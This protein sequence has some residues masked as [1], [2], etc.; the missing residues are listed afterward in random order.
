MDDSKKNILHVYDKTGKF[1][2]EIILE[3]KKSFLDEMLDHNIQVF[4]GCMGGSCSACKC[5]ILSGNE[6]VDKEAMGPQVYSDVKEDEI[7]SCIA[8]VK[9]NS[10]GKVIEIQKLL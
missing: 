4:Y 6:F 1:E 8:K 9:E 2:K 10:F 3:G 7:L 5:K